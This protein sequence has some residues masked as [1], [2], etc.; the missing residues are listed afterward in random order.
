ML[1]FQP[2]GNLSAPSLGVTGVGSRLRLPN[3]MTFRGPNG[4][5]YRFTP[6]AEAYL[7]SHTGPA[8]NPPPG[9]LNLAGELDLPFF[10]GLKI[11]IHTSASPQASNATLHLMGGWP[12]AGV[13]PHYGWNDAAGKNYFSTAAFDPDNLGLPA[14]T[15]PDAYRNGAGQ[16]YHPRAQKL[17]LGVVPFDYPLAWSSGARIFRSLQPVTNDLY[18][19]TLSHR[20]EYLGPETA[21][22]DFA[23]QFTG[24]PRINL[25]N[26]AVNQLDNQLGVGHAFAQAAGGE[27]FG[28]VKGGLDHLDEMLDAQVQS[29]FRSVFDRTIDPF[30]DELYGA[31]HTNYVALTN[32]CEF[33]RVAI[34]NIHHFVTSTNRGLNSL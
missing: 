18:V 9:W 7:N 32:K 22:L 3:A 33:K 14:D 16:Q 31:M 8:A 2:N 29:F 21:D 6:V 20:V 26:F 1:G 23:S 27:V 17:W 4:E 10:E 19:L 15:L 25:A 5:D 28:A 34:S 24:L 30:I 11:H 12:R 13:G